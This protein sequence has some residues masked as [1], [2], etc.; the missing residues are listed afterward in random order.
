ME[1]FVYYEVHLDYMYETAEGGNQ[2]SGPDYITQHVTNKKTCRFTS[3]DNAERHLN[4]FLESR[5]DDEVW[6]D[7]KCSHPILKYLKL[8][9]DNSPYGKKEYRAYIT[10]KTFD[11]KFN[12]GIVQLEIEQAKNYGGKEN[13]TE[14]S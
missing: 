11:C 14:A 2:W 13:P 8:I 10:E 7:E 6:L 5:P 9:T 4:G 1:K 12:D 3:R